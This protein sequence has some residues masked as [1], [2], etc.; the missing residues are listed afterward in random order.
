MI[1]AN[2]PLLIAELIWPL[3]QLHI[4]L[5]AQ[6]GSPSWGMGYEE[7]E[8]LLLRRAR[9]TTPVNVSTHEGATETSAVQTIV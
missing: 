6:S 2:E 5:Q 9:M 3:D 7:T 1:F 4:A 8:F